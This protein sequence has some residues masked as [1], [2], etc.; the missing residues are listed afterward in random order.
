MADND[1]LPS[2][3]N[4]PVVPG[5]DRWE[6][7]DG[8]DMVVDT[9]NAPLAAPLDAVAV[10]GDVVVVVVV[11]DVVVAL[12]LVFV[13]VRAP[14]KADAKDEQR[15][16]VWLVDESCWLAVPRFRHQTHSLPIRATNVVANAS[17]STVDLWEGV[18]LPLPD[19]MLC[20][21]WHWR[22]LRCW[23]R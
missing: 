10:V 5:V 15:E 12:R 1:F 4:H 13:V 6:Q 8:V 9:S 3:P 7:L 18:I 11:V 16:K 14:H 22:L 19:T 17:H 2:V 21:G 20:S 23:S